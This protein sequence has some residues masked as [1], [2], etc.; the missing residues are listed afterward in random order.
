[1]VDKTIVTLGNIAFDFVKTLKATTR[2]NLQLITQE[3]HPGGRAFNQA[4]IVARLGNRHIQ[5]YLLGS[6][7]Y[8]GSL[9]IDHV[10]SAQINTDY[11]FTN[12]SYATDKVDVELVIGE[13]TP[14]TIGNPGASYYLTI[15]Q[16]QAATEVLKKAHVIVATAGIPLYILKQ[17][18]ETNFS[19]KTT[20][21]LRPAPIDYMDQTFH[22]QNPICVDI[23][24]QTDYLVI[25]DNEIAPFLSQTG[26]HLDHLLQD[27]LGWVRKGIIVAENGIPQYL[28]TKQNG[29][30]SIYQHSLAIEDAAAALDT[31]CGA[32]AVQ[33][34]LGTKELDAFHYGVV[35]AHRCAQ[36]NGA[37]SSLPYYGQV[38]LLWQKAR[39][40]KLSKPYERLCDLFLPIFTEHHNNQTK[41]SFWVKNNGNRSS[42]L[43]PI[44]YDFSGDASKLTIIKHDQQRFGVLAITDKQAFETTGWMAFEDISQTRLDSKQKA[45]VLKII[46]QYLDNLP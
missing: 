39:S 29:Y 18:F 43:T 31:F 16:L 35:A 17:A 6:V 19:Q 36:E 14:R 23:L 21:I 7:G 9:I 41:I 44:D 25:E 24:K 15:D 30:V 34:A 1:M 8:D 38:E 27:C 22:T 37:F 45:I 28:F 26:H 12:L 4:I 10:K 42:F 20:T 40:G 46:R 5:S 13:T 2:K 11:L 3:Q 32:F 33:L